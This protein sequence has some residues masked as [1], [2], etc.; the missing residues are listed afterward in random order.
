MRRLLIIFAILASSD[1]D[2]LSQTV[3][4]IAP[5][6]AAQYLV[7]SGVTVSN[8]MFV[9]E[10]EQ[11]SRITGAPGQLGFPDGIAI[12]TNKRTYLQSGVQ[13]EMAADHTVSNNFVDP[14]Q[15]NGN[16]SMYSRAY[17]EFDFVT[18]GSQISFD[19]VFSS[20]EYPGY[21]CCIYNDVFGF[22]ISGPGITGKQNMA[23]VPGT[24]D[25]IAINTV[26]NGIPACSGNQC[27]PTIHTSQFNNNAWFYGGSTKVITVTYD[28]QCQQTY[29]LKMAICNT[30][31]KYYNSA[32]FIKRQSLKSDFNLG[33]VSANVQPIC[34]GQNLTL[35][36]TGSDGYVYTWKDGNG[37]T[38]ASGTDMRQITI[39]ATTSNSV[40]SVSITSPEGCT[41]TQ[42]INVVVHSQNNN[43]PYVNGINNTGEYNVY[44]VAGEQICFNIPSFDDM[45]EEVTMVWNDGITTASFQ[46]VTPPFPTGT[47][48]WTPTQGQVGWH[49]FTITVTDDNACG[50][51]SANYTFH[52]KVIC[53]WHLL[54]VE[55][56]N[57]TPQSNPLPAYTSAGKCIRAGFSQPVVVGT[58]AVTFEAPEIDLGTFFDGTPPHFDAIVN[59]NTSIFDCESCC[60]N[61]SGFTIDTPIPN[62]FSPNGDGINEYWFAGDLDN[63]MCAFNA[64][65]FE[66]Y[67]VDRWG[68]TVYSQTDNVNLQDNHCCPYRAPGDPA[69]SGHSSIFWN[70]YANHSTVHNWWQKLF[71]GAKDVNSGELVNQ[72]YYF[73]VL[74]LYGCGHNQTYQGFI[75]VSLSSGMIQAGGDPVI[76]SAPEQ[77][78]DLKP[79]YPQEN[80]S[81]VN[82]GTTE[83]DKEWIATAYPNPVKDVLVIQSSVEHCGVIIYD[84]SGKK[85]YSKIKM[86]YSEQVNTTN[87]ESGLYTVVLQAPGGL[88]KEFTI[89]KN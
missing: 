58:A 4:A 39:P 77:I 35:T 78:P 26:N 66:L 84:A 19:F 86:N 81:V 10:P 38:V 61:F 76:V 32:V 75:Y 88:I 67:I 7:G 28:V 82:V 83:A 16:G 42:S 53:S 13:N 31:D 85:V 41:L 18:T 24:S 40:Y 80:S 54:C 22:F 89:V 74:T 63:P 62:V 8:A 1:F 46:V 60:D 52:V 23:L 17:L 20:N 33:A 44:V 36:T 34:E 27:G 43:P 47:F 15:L 70:G 68:L 49:S 30:G 51:Q 45:G 64:K 72:D 25:P 37:Q 65:G 48:C 21:N 69:T 57:R 14:D 79:F 87:F 6:D 3:S 56:E 73:Y 9:G 12:T 59:Y 29:R 71:Q 2:L 55:Y 50:T 5:I 11:L